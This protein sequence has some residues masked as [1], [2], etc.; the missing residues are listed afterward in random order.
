MLLLAA[1]VA[2]GEP[3]EPRVR[4]V[5]ADRDP[6]LRRAIVET[7][8]P[9]PI[10]V[11]FEAV[12]PASTAV[13][14]TRAHAEYARY[15]VW[16]RD[17]DLF[18]YD[19]DRGAA[20]LRESVRGH[21]DDANATA[22]AL[23]VKSLLRL[24][25]IASTPP[26]PITTSTPLVAPTSP[27][28][29]HGTTAPAPVAHPR[30]RGQVGAAGRIAR[31]SETALGGRVTVAAATRPIAS[32]PWWVGL[33][34]EVGTPAT[35]DAP[36]FKGHWTDATARVVT[37]GVAALGSLAIEPHVGLGLTSSHVTATRAG[38][39]LDDRVAVATVRVGL[40]VRWSRGALSAGLD[41]SADA[42]LGTATYTKPMG[43]GILYEVPGF[44]L[45]VG[46]FLAL[47]VP[48]K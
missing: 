44:A 37:S 10:D 14:V 6:A 17:G 35:I 21:L 19:A 22:A 3:R 1:R 12:A 13:A 45:S 43:S 41:V 18:V 16:R 25:P 40:A 11:V 38:A 7:L 48:A 8:A 34:G 36:S 20:E 47:A 27:P 15:V 33:E 46:G 5:V 2:T 29:V 30:W 24:R 28:A 32:L 23:S 31:G 9:W 39:R 42:W 26:P 4:V